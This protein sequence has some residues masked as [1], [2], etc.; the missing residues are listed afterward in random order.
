MGTWFNNSTWLLNDS[1]TLVKY[2]SKNMGRLL[3]QAQVYKNYAQH[4]NVGVFQ[5][6]VFEGGAF[7]GGQ[8]G[9]RGRSMPS[10]PAAEL[11]RSTKK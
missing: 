9:G 1:N 4:Y 2:N 8:K 5:G 6:G 11:T 10:A 7:E 3:R